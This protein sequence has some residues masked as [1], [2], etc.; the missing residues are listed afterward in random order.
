MSPIDAIVRNGA[1]NQA[2]PV[3]K[4]CPLKH[5]N[6]MKN[7]IQNCHSEGPLIGFCVKIYSNTVCATQICAHMSKNTKSQ[8]NVEVLTS[9]CC[10]SS[11][12][13]GQ[14]VKYYS[15]L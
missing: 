5:L 13:A 8:Q 6:E 2:N 3:G 4:G 10:V 12:G 9:W 15:H 14:N 7:R 1:W 11:S